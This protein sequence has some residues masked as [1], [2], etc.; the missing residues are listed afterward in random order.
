MLLGTQCVI[1]IHQASSL[2]SKALTEHSKN[3]SINLIV[4][5][6]NDHRDRSIGLVEILIKTVKSIFGCMKKDRRKTSVF[7]H[8]F[9]ELLA[10]LRTTVQKT[11]GL[12][13]CKAHSGRKPNSSLSNISTKPTWVNLNWDKNPKSC[14]DKKKL[15]HA[16]I[17]VKKAPR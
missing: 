11:I 14:L 1:R 3:N 6:A 8:S 12:T 16:L 10:A 17:S 5:S 4:A 9:Y 2:I 13:Q 15:G 7:D